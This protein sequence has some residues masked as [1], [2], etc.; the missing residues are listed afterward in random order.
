MVCDTMWHYNYVLLS[1]KD[2]RGKKCLRY[3]LISSHDPGQMRLGCHDVS[4]TNQDLSPLSVLRTCTS[5]RSFPVHPVP[6][7]SLPVSL[8][9]QF[10]GELPWGGCH[11]VNISN[12]GVSPLSVV[13]DMHTCDNSTPCSRIFS[14]SLNSSLEDCLGDCDMTWYISKVGKL[15]TFHKW[16]MVF[17]SLHMNKHYL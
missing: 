16:Q 14:V 8:P 10:P 15:S 6:G 3:Y 1:T 12:Q 5:V 17:D 11:D 13:S 4:I 9:Q 7:F 2:K